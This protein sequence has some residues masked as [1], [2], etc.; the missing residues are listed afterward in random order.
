MSKK[1]LADATFINLTHSLAQNASTNLNFESVAFSQLNPQ[2]NFIDF[3]V[4]LVVAVVVIGLL[5]LNL[6]SSLF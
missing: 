1:S 3:V 4:V 2:V 6:V 5:L